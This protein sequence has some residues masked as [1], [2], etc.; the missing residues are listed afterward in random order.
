M[1]EVITLVNDR[2]QAGWSAFPVKSIV[3]VNPNILE[4]FVVE[5]NGDNNM[6]YCFINP[7]N[8]QCIITVYHNSLSVS[9]ST[10]LGKVLYIIMD[11]VS[12]LISLQFEKYQKKV[13]FYF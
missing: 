7:I 5:K 10:L 9:L 6:K 13:T 2:I 3:H 4:F 1:C 8:I 11:S 12:C